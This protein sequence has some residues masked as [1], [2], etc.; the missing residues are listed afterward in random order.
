MTASSSPRPCTL[1]YGNQS[2]LVDRSAE[3]W[4]AQ[5]LGDAPRDFAFHRFDAD[6]MLRAGGAEAV[7]QRIDAF[8]EA[9][10]ALPL[11]GDRYVVR[12]DRA[13]RVRPPARAAQTVEKALAALRV[14]R[15]RWEG[16]AAWAPEGALPPGTGPEEVAA[17]ER[18]VAAVGPTG[19]GRVRLTLCDDVPAGPFLLPRGR[20]HEAVG[21]PAFLRA[22]VKGKLVFAG[23]EPETPEEGGPGSAAPATAAA[24][25]HQLLLHVLEQPPAGCHL[26]LTA[27]ATR[28]RDLSTELLGRLKRVGTVTKHVTYDDNLPVDWV[29]REARERGLRLTAD[30]AGELIRALGNDLRVLSHELDK[31]ALLFAFGDEPGG[32]TLRQAIRGAAPVS[33]F[34]IAERLG[35]RDLSGALH[36]LTRFFRE[37]PQQHPVLVGALARHFRQLYLI[38]A[39]RQ[40]G[41]TEADLAARLKLPPFI[42]RKLGREAGRFSSPELEG[43]LH[44]LA[45]LDV[46][47]KLRGALTPLLFAHFAQR[48]CAGD[49]GRR[50]ARAL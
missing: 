42:A 3:A 43:I 20:G 36:G 27:E 24:R 30:D 41:A 22:Q 39:L 7:S 33:V 35:Q 44:G 18:W 6:E 17:L 38:H 32:P 11:L 50:G 16:E 9:C 26:V 15:V 14:C 37:T 8:E 40:G 28:E 12:L 48:V 29:L 1:I 23:E 31:L 25:L 46:D 5:V 34:L 10:L 47:A 49:Y 13:E 19:D 45:G 2:L 4:T 21:L